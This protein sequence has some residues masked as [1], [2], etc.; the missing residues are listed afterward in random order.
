MT[1]QCRL[2]FFGTELFSVPTLLGLLDAGY[3]IAAI[4]TKPDTVR[5]RGKKSFVHPIKQMGID[6]GIPILQPEKLGDIEVE[7]RSLNTQ[8]AVLV[9]YGK[10]IPRRILNVFEPIGIINI[11]PS[12]LPELRGPS[13]IEATIL[14]GTKVTAVSI[15]KLDEGMDTGPLYLQKDVTLTGTETKPELSKRLS[16]IGRDALLEALPGIITGQLQPS[17]QKKID[18]SVTSLTSK[19]DGVL[20]PTTEEAAMLERKVRA[21]QE[22]PKPHLR[23][24]D[25][26]VIVTSAKVVTSPTANTLVI[27]CANKTRLEITSLIAPSGRAMSG[28]AFLRGY[29]KN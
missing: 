7:L 24:F 25:N 15:M 6:H 9:S 10:I 19:T 21:Y 1:T 27:P 17:P 20:S 22:Y 5:G 2:V 23:L 16:E 28:E 26:D 11:H 14:S 18:V 3:D 13:P 8:C 4:V 29:A 12:R